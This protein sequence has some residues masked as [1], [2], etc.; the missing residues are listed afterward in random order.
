MGVIFFGRGMHGWME[1]K[2]DLMDCNAESKK[3]KWFLDNSPFNVA[4]ACIKVTTDSCIKV[5]YLI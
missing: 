3:L 4:L 1:T 2:A 5:T